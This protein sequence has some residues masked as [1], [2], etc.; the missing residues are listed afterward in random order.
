MAK[1]KKA[2][3]KV[4]KKAKKKVA[5]KAKKKTV[6]KKRPAKKLTEKPR[7]APKTTAKKPEK[8]KKK[9]AGPYKHP[10][11]GKFI[12][13][14]A[15]LAI[16][17][18]VKKK[19]PKIPKVRKKKREQDIEADKMEQAFDTLAQDLSKYKVTTSYRVAKQADGSVHGQVAIYNLPMNKTVG[20]MTN[21]IEGIF[22]PPDDQ[23]MWVQFLLPP[24]TLDFDAEG[25]A[26]YPRDAKTGMF[27]ISSYD[28]DVDNSAYAF[29]AARSI[30]KEVTAIRGRRRPQAVMIDLWWHP[31]GLRP[32]MKRGKK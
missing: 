25:K 2:K 10:K 16:V 24:T 18:R 12:S 32:E 17:R 8:P 23:R 14:K 28:Y 6:K 9:E 19:P 20:W 27:K 26:L 31:Q 29:D 15:Y 13:R 11:T 7:L 1:A 30:M 4:A 3:K 21:E 22:V 5:K